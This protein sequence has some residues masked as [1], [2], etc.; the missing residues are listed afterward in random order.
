MS[1]CPECGAPL[2]AS[3]IQ[4]E[5][6]KKLHTFKLIRE[7]ALEGGVF[8]VFKTGELIPQFKTVE[9]EWKA[10]IPFKSC[11][12]E[13]TYRLEPKYY[14]RGMYRAI[15][16]LDVEGRTHILIHVANFANDL[17]GCIGVGEKITEIGKWLGVAKSRH[18]FN[19]LLNLL[20]ELWDKGDEIQLE[21]SSISLTY[22]I[23]N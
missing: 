17:Q 18:T 2:K 9:K 22:N 3:P 11:I 1:T 4:Q 5:E 21:I 6:T 12:P 13:G 16:L 20:S 8:G 19:I 7:A 10:N 23:Q 15:Q 14:N